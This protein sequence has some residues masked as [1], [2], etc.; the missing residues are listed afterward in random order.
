MEFILMM[1]GGFILVVVGFLLFIKMVFSFI[2]WLESHTL[3]YILSWPFL[4]VFGLIVVVFNLDGK[5]AQS[6]INPKPHYRYNQATGQ[7]ERIL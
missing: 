7:A 5:R 3:G 6:R 4:F 2:S 1:L